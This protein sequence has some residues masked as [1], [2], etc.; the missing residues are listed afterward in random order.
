M[1][2]WTKHKGGATYWD[3]LSTRHSCP[4]NDFAGAKSTDDAG[5]TDEFTT[6]GRILLLPASPEYEMV[7]LCSKGM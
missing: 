7:P 3:L 1:M 2:Q 5:H 6:G 4:S